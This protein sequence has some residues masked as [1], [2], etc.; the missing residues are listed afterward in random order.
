M[1]ITFA[2][3]KTKEKT[4][5]VAKTKKGGKE[6]L[7]HQ[8][9]H[10]VDELGAVQHKIAEASTIIDDKVKELSETLKVT[11]L[12]H[13][14]ADGVKAFKELAVDYG[15]K[16]DAK[17]HVEGEKYV[18]DLGAEATARSIIDKGELITILEGIE[19][20]LAL[21]LASFKLGD[22]DAYLNPNQIA[23]VVKKDFTGKRNFKIK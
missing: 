3:K 5:A 18:G 8:M 9:E 22:L 2:K 15:V 10:K 13:T 14:L 6:T 21:K 17:L 12:N 11:E 19:E 7:L 4:K 23:K 16:K 1:A 20:G